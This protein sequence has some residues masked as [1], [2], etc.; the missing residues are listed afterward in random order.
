MGDSLDDSNSPTRSG[1][2]RGIKF[3]PQGGKDQK[4]HNTIK[5]YNSRVNDYRPGFDLK[6]ISQFIIIPSFLRCFLINLHMVRFLIKHPRGPNFDS[7]KK[8]IPTECEDRILIRASEEGM[9]ND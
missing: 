3:E 5:P 9:N 6:N 7:K 4:G 2:D 8:K 1:C